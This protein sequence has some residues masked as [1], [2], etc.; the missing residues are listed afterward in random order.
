MGDAID[1]M[2]IA[3]GDDR[4]TPVR[5]QLGSSLYM[6]GRVGELSGVKVVSVVPGNP[7]GLVAVFDGRGSPLGIV[8]GAALTSIRTGAAC[9]LATDLLA[10]PSAGVLAMLGAGAMAAD[11][12][13]AVRAV[14]RI[15]RVLV[16]SRS[17][18]RANEL[19][20]RVGGEV[21]L[22]PSEAVAAAD[23]VDCATPA[24]A[25]LFAA[26]AVTPGTHFNAVGAFTPDMVELPAALVRDAFVVVDDRA[27]AAV[28]AGDLLQANREP[29][30]TLGDIVSGRRGRGHG[31]Q[32]TVFKS[33]GI[34]SQDIAAAGRA[35]HN[36]AELGIGVLLD[37]STG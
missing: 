16:W 25:P 23:I 10:S 28:E 3:F 8:D 20:E 12:I 27:A 1:A 19:A 15:D 7:T 30:A 14:R 24:T 5:H 2:R 36:A 35:L 11:Q 13:A 31:R 18:D 29:D 33:V 21:V 9:G 22:D 4:E 26:G 37:G 32:P 34:A 17:S 6:T